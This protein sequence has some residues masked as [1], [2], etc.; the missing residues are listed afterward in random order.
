[1]QPLHNLKPAEGG[2]E[3]RLGCVRPGS[4]CGPRPFILKPREAARVLFDGMRLFENERVASAGI[5]RETI[6]WRIR[7]DNW[8]SVRWVTVAQYAPELLRLRNDLH[9]FIPKQ[10]WPFALPGIRNF[11][12][13]LHWMEITE[14]LGEPVFAFCDAM[15][16]P[17]VELGW[18]LFEGEQTY[19]GYAWTRKAREWYAQA[20]GTAENTAA[21]PT[22]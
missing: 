7:E 2:A 6:Y 15:G 10:V 5:K 3:A 12:L 20:R 4:F 9:P 17:G 18:P 21:R 16:L 14:A 22:R 11:K 8:T 1:M 19:P 13:T